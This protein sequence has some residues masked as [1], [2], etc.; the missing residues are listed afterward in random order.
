MSDVKAEPLTA[1]DEARWREMI[2]GE[3]DG[4]ARLLRRYFATID[5]LRSKLSAVEG[6]R[7]KLKRA[8]DEYEAVCDLARRL[9]ADRDAAFAKGR[10]EGDANYSVAYD[11]AD[12]LLGL[13]HGYVSRLRAD[14][15]LEWSEKIAELN[16]LPKPIRSLP[17]P[18][19]PEGP[20]ESIVAGLAEAVAFAKGEGEAR[21]TV[22][23]PTQQ[24][25]VAP[26]GA[27]SPPVPQGEGETVPL[28]EALEW[29]TRA[30][31]AEADAARLREAGWTLAKVLRSRGVG[32]VFVNSLD[33]DR[34]DA[35]AVFEA[36]LSPEAKTTEG[37]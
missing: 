3:H 34:Y 17:H 36:A 28:S 10:A 14:D 9:E 21:V 11:M 15:K 1:E 16:R 29:R 13:L 32:E 25:A 22:V 12:R 24:P 8:D 19:S 4:F 33:R 5:S 6:E 7:D 23:D 31:A 27:L 2:K 20:A 26:G 30:L 18:G 35:M 37:E